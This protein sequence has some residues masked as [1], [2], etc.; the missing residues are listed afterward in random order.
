MRGVP[1]VFVKE[2]RVMKL[3]RADDPGIRAAA[4]G[5]VRK[6][7]MYVPIL[8]ELLQDHDR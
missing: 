7:P 6:G 3:L 1:E 4:A 5:C 8:I 2:P